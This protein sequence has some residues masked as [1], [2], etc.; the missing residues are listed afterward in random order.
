VLAT[1]RRDQLEAAGETW[2]AADEE[3]VRA[4]IRDQ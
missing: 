4:P 1:V 2:S 3:A